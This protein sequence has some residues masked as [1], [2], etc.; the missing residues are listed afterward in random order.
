MNQFNRI[1]VWALIALSLATT[2]IQADDKPA[3]LAPLDGIDLATYPVGPGDVLEISIWKEPDLLHQIVV[4]PD[5]VIS[6]THAGKIKVQGKTIDEIQTILE[7]RLGQIIVDPIVT[8][9]LMSY[10]SNKIYVI[11]KVNRP[12]EFPVTGLVDVMQALAMAGGMAS[13]ADKDSVNILRRRNGTLTS[14][15]F[16]YSEVADGENL[17]QNIILEKGDVVVVQ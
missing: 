13:F 10:P 3:A 7:E 4:P 17:Q 8:V 15:P 6:F 1:F 9:F 12:G 14:I 11:G 2:L 5:G 16:D